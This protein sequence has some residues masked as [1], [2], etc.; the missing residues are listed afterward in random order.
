MESVT[1]TA[2]YTLHCSLQHQ[3]F[4]FVIIFLHLCHSQIL[5]AWLAA[6]VFGVF[7]VL[8]ENTIHDV[9]NLG[10]DWLKQN[11]Q[12][13]HGTITGADI[14][15][16][17]SLADGLFHLGKC[18]L[19]FLNVRKSVSGSF[20]GNHY[21]VAAAAASY[22][23]LVHVFIL[24]GK[25]PVVKIQGTCVASA[26]AEGICN[27]AKISCNACRARSLVVN[28]LIEGKLVFP[29]LLH[30]IQSLICLGVAVCEGVA[31]GTQAKTGRKGSIADFCIC[32]CNGVELF[33]QL[34]HGV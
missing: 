13:L 15:T 1:L 16:A 32:L 5:V 27:L 33:K 6:V 7:V 17:D 3:S 10:F 34:R 26:L 20:H 24:P 22:D 23:Q 31:D 14:N 11:D 28:L 12:V 8:Y 18:L 29:I 19:N 30:K 9:W 21:Q 2:S 4:L 25:I